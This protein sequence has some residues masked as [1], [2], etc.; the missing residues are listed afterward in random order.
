MDREQDATREQDC[1][2]KEAEALVEILIAEE[3]KKL[4]PSA[5]CVHQRIIDDVL[6]RNGKR[7]GKV[8]CCK[9][10]AIFDDPYQDQK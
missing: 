4:T 8:R 7:T 2:S 5:A 9:C 10:G 6:N 1:I 3:A